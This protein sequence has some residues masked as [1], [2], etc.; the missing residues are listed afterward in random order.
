M[1]R[2]YMHSPCTLHPYRSHQIPQVFRSNEFV[3]LTAPLSLGLS[4]HHSCEFDTFV[5]LRDTDN[6]GTHS[7][8]S[9][10]NHKCLSRKLSH[11]E[12]FQL[13]ETARR[14]SHTIIGDFAQ[15]EPAL[16]SGYLIGSWWDRHQSCYRNME[17]TPFAQTLNLCDLAISLIGRRRLLV[18]STA[19]KCPG[20]VE[21][22]RSLS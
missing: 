19:G 13:R 10:S 5:R 16:Y 1:H 14:I 12:F 15:I 7:T 21:V 11:F 9:C 3:V 8:S 18:T 6:A 4:F 22:Q 2:R 17:L 20:A